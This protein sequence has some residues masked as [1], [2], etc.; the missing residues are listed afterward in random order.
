MTR[1]DYVLIAEAFADAGTDADKHGDDD[2]RA[3]FWGLH[4]AATYIADGLVQDNPRFD[5][6][7]FMAAC[8]LAS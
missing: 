8:G 3:R 5:R 6:A 1:K 4:T 7:R 2:Q